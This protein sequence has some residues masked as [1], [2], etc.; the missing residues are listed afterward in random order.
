MSLEASIL[1]QTVTESPLPVVP[2]NKT[3]TTTDIFVKLK[4]YI[5]LWT[6]ASNPVMLLKK[7]TNGYKTIKA[8]PPSGSFVP[9]GLGNNNAY[10]VK[11]T[12][13]CSI[14]LYFIDV[15]TDA[16]TSS[17]VTVSTATNNAGNNFAV[18]VINGMVYVAAIET[19]SAFLYA[20]TVNFTNKTISFTK[21]L[22]FTSTGSAASPIIAYFC[23]ITASAFHF[24]GTTTLGTAVWGL[25]TF[26][27]GVINRTNASYSG[28]G[29][30]QNDSVVAVVHTASSVFAYTPSAAV[31]LYQIK[32]S[33]VTDASTSTPAPV[34]APTYN[35]C[36]LYI[37]NI[38]GESFINLYTLEGYYYSIKGD[39]CTLTSP[40]GFP[41]QTAVCANSCG[42]SRLGPVVDGVLFV[43]DAYNQSIYYTVPAVYKDGAIVA[44]TKRIKIYTNTTAKTQLITSVAVAVNGQHVGDG[45]YPLSIAMQPKNTMGLSLNDKPFFIDAFDCSVVHAFAN[46]PIA[47]KP[48]EFISL[49]ILNSFGDISVTINGIV[50]TTQA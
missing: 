32:A 22:I 25:Y 28:T 29:L 8:L 48:N 17:Q 6:G 12:A 30:N 9:M 47:L 20:G 45:G 46:C 2:R 10:V 41:P 15:E 40:V 33:Q 3:N 26:L 18:D 34:S 44:A 50:D 14:T 27:S 31:T 11:N 36:M 42:Y 5:L 39:A 35:T 7:T 1:S 21:T 4:D 13:N 38:S 49:D 43:L 19:A 37:D 16:V 24:Q 23:M